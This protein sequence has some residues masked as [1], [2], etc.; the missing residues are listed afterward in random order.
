MKYYIEL[1]GNKFEVELISDRSK[2]TILLNK[3]QFQAEELLFNDS[4]G[5]FLLDNQLLDLEYTSRQ[6]ELDLHWKGR[7]HR[8]KIGNLLTEPIF[9]FLH[10]IDRKSESKHLKSP[11]P[12]VIV[13][14]EVKP[15]ESVQ[16]GQGVVIIEAMKME[17]EIK[18]PFAGVVKEILVSERE[19]VD[20][21]Q[22][23][24]K[25]E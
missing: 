1:A 2:L 7:K 5:V 18:S 21:N 12:G 19:P 3:K 4:R 14:I 24:I 10:E 25:Y 13:K 22:V 9:D 11:L 16:D 8:V 23:L 20:K 17:N 6:G 15:G